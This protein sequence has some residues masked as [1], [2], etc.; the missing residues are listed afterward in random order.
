MIL[1]YSMYDECLH[2]LRHGVGMLQV[3]SGL[4]QGEKKKE[5]R[6]RDFLLSFSFLYP[7][8]FLILRAKVGGGGR[9][10]GKKKG[11]YRNNRVKG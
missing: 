6:H 8:F 1:G 2:H 3:V 4:D 10:V 5:V 11:R 9:K 7:S